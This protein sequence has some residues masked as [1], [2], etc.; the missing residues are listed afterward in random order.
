MQKHLKYTAIF[1]LMVVVYPFLFQSLHIIY[2]DHQHGSGHI[3]GI[4]PVSR[5]SCSVHT[6]L[7]SHAGSHEPEKDPPAGPGSDSKTGRSPGLI[8]CTVNDHE[9]FHSH[10]E[11]PVCEH[12]F[13]KF[14]LDNTSY[15][16]FTEDIIAII[17]PLFYL[18]P[19][20]LY[21]GNHK[22]LRA[23]PLLS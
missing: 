17:S 21:T 22:L 7:C 4:S 14:S 6:G 3:P 10:E 23:P 13:A 12:E 9:P 8:F 15:T 16:L 19:A 1:I 2:H 18:E 20:I 11:C 5:N